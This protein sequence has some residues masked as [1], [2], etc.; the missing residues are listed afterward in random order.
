VEYQQFGPL[1]LFIEVFVAMTPT[2]KA[3]ALSPK[4][5]PVVSAGHLQLSILAIPS[6]REGHVF[7]P[8]NQ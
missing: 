4:H 2:G 7:S 3:A 5:E 1:A 6:V 8:A